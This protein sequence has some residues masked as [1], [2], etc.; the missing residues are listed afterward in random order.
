MSGLGR[1]YASTHLLF[2]LGSNAC[3]LLFDWL[4]T[5]CPIRERNHYM[6][7]LAAIKMKN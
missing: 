3:P 1:I 5:C 7:I 6:I 4:I 2:L